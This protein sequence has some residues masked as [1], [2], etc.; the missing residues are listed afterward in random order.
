MTKKHFIA[1]AEW[2]KSANNPNG[3]E[4][5]R[6]G[7]KQVKILADFCAQQNPN[8]DRSRWLG[9]ISGENGPNGG[10]ARK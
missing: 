3:P 7:D 10:S 2:I 5:Q 8:F 4:D 1:L 6:F 9:Y